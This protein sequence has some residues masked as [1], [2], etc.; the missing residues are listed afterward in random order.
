[1]PLQWIGL[2]LVKPPDGA[3]VESVLFDL[4]VGASKKLGGKLF[5]C[6][7]YGLSGGV[8]PLVAHRACTEFPALWGEKLCFRVVIDS[9][10]CY[11]ITSCLQPDPFGG[12]RFAECHLLRTFHWF[13]VLLSDWT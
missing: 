12:I 8:E 5:D 7:T 10:H 13:G 4:K 6:K 9:G 11:R 3:A 1:M 2:A